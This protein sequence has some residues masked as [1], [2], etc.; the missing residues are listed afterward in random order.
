M[1]LL[2]GRYLAA[3]CFFFLL[4]AFASTLMSVQGIIISCLLLL[5]TAVAATFVLIKLSRTKEKRLLSLTALISILCAA[6]ALIN[7]ALFIIRPRLQA[8]EHL[9]EGVA[10]VKIL[11]CEYLYED[12]SKYTVRVEKI[13]EDECNFKAYVYSD[14]ALS[15]EY[16]ERMIT[17]F[18]IEGM[19]F[20]NMSAYSEGILLNMT[21]LD[22]KIY[23]QAPSPTSLLSPDGLRAVTDNIRE[24]FI[25]YVDTLF[26]GESRGL[27]KGFLIND[28]SELPDST[29]A[30]FRRSG[31]SHLLA[32]SGLH[33]AL[34]LGSFDW[35]LRKL[36]IQ[37]RIRCAV[38]SFFG[39]I[40]IA[41]TDFSPSAV[42]SFFML[43]SVYLMY[44]F[45][46]DTDAIT[47]LFA[48]VAVI[49]LVSPYSVYDIGLWM[50]FLATLGLVSVYPVLEAKLS[51]GIKKDKKLSKSK[52]LAFL[53][54]IGNAI[55]RGVL[56]TLVANCFLL[57][58]FWYFFGA[59]SVAAVP[60]NIVMSPLSAVYLPLA[61]VSVALG[62]IPFLGDALIFL[63]SALGELI[64]TLA[65]VFSTWRGAVVSLGYPFVTPLI[66][67]FMV[68][69]VPMLFVKLKNKTLV[70]VP[71]V[72]FV[73][74]FSVCLG[75]FLLT[76]KPK[77]YTAGENDDFVIYETAGKL[78]VADYS[79]GYGSD[80]ISLLNSLPQY[81]S[82]I[83][84][85]VL[86]NEDG[87]EKRQITYFRE[88]MSNIYVRE[89]YLPY[90]SNAEDAELLAEIYTLA[91]SFG[92]EVIIYDGAD[93]IISINN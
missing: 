64:V 13:D 7:S 21:V 48:S 32:V 19:L 25:S 91:E 6:A 28:T 12:S 47:S 22:G 41:L 86:K 52:P 18:D 43:I 55:L 4:A 76:F 67:L 16:G 3:I 65:N 23:T 15:L 27:V 54:R 81:A 58:V 70:C 29:R 39:V 73:L 85:Y 72:A 36:Y 92:T 90:A 42:R 14:F 2:K 82:E 46:E 40:F 50:S 59:I 20:D 87:V 34:L 31:T 10:E 35:L 69:F 45:A 66:F 83:E 84:R 74:S 53:L 89:L 77:S 62:K 30:S 11:S 38:V 51:R 75:V 93:G 60:A 9:G 17:R 49:M 44:A 88:L 80:R 71:F 78:Y 56:I 57:P 1:A 8:L 79:K 61:A 26:D 68:A 24:G 5:L 33:I 63:T 37:K